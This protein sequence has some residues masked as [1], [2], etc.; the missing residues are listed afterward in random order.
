MA[1]LYV[2]ILFSILLAGIL[3]AFFIW[4]VHAGQWDDLNTP[5]KRLLTEELDEKY[6]TQ[7]D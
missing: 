6:P 5:A 2:V 3:S 4:A 7:R 1:G